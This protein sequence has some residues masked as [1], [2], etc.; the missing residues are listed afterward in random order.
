MITMKKKNK[1]KIVYEKI[2]IDENTSEPIIVDVPIKDVEDNFEKHEPLPPPHED[3]E[4]AGNQIIMNKLFGLEDEKEDE[5]VSKRQRLFKKLSSW[6]FVL[7]VGIVLGV[8]VY[9]DFFSGKEVLSLSEMMGVL[10]NNIQ[11]F[12]YSVVALIFCYLLKGVK[13]SFFCKRE[14]GKWHFKTCLGTAT[15]GHYYNYITPLAVGGQP[16]EIYHLSKNGVHGGVAASL[17]IASFFL[18]QFAFVLLAIASLVLYNTNALNSPQ[19]LQFLDAGLT[20]VAIV[21]IVCCFTVP[22]LVVLFCILPRISYKIVYF[23]IWL[24]SKIGLVKD[25]RTLN[26]KMTKS[27]LQNS[28]SLKSFVSNPFVLIVSLLISIG[29]NLALCSIAY[30]S[31][32]FF[33]YSLV[34]NGGIVEW[35]Q[36]CVVCMLLYSAISFIP[37][38]GNS[39]A[40]DLSFHYFFKKGLGSIGGVAFPATML[41][42]FMSFYSF[43]IIGFIFTKVNKAKEKKKKRSNK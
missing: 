18:Q 29:E 16:F 2:E 14:T 4:S 32:K 35:A 13:L 27:I 40:A 33:G 10:G 26:Y 7:F 5:N 1:E 9:E 20:A 31:L 42:R 36:V 43:I 12:I 37:T 17:P 8:T 6:F 19:T 21:G 38:P 23:V 28:K 39:G 22:F 11:Y 34:G 15:I 30:F 3:M 25:R 24:G 41:W